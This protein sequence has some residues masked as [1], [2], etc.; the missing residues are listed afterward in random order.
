MGDDRPG[1]GLCGWLGRQVGY[2]RRA[3][4]AKVRPTQSPRIVYREE[5]VEEKPLP[6]AKG[7]TLRRTVVDEV[8]VE[9]EKGQQA[10][11]E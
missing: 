8:V 5:K 11:R 9:G 2:V 6:G 1:A 4:R 3:V 10:A 7:V